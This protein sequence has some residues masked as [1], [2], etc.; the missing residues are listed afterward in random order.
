MKTWF[1]VLAGLNAASVIRLARFGPGDM[2]SRSLLAFIAAAPMENEDLSAIP[3]TEMAEL[4]EGPQ[5][6]MTIGSMSGVD[7]AMPTRDAIAMLAIATAANP[8]TVLEIGTFIGR[9]TALLAQ[10][11]PAATIHTIDLPPDF[12]PGTDPDTRLKKDDFHLISTRK[13][14]IC[15]RDTPIASRIVQHYGDT[16]SWDFGRAAGA[17]L[18]FI[19]GS[20]TYDYVRNDTERC[21][22]LCGGRGTF[23]WHDCDSN[24]PAIARYLH[25]ELRKGHPIRR[26]AGTSA[27]FSTMDREPARS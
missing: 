6:S 1:Q 26:A 14:G 25:E 8:K 5:R 19:D 27:A 20:H 15:F 3:V 18:F 11:L 24:H 2:A 22:E 7:G 17:E 13:V 4:M 21:R 23:I 10:N 9:T 16:G 12:D